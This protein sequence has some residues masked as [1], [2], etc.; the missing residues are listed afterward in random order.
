MAFLLGGLAILIAPALL[1]VGLRRVASANQN[2]QSSVQNQ[3][4]TLFVAISVGV[5]GL[6]TALTALLA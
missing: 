3:T 6:L 1:M 2:W 4:G 5:I